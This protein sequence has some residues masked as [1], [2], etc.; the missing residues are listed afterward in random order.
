MNTSFKG[1]IHNIKPLISLLKAIQ[2]K[3]LASCSIFAEGLTFTV[4]ESRCVKAVAYVKKHLFTKYYKDP[5]TENFIF[6]IPLNT[7]IDCLGII[8]PFT[9]NRGNTD[10][11]CEMNY[12]GPGSRFRIAFENKEISQLLQFNLDT[13]QPDE[14]NTDLSITDEVG[15]TQKMII[16]SSWLKSALNDLDKSCQTISMTFSP[17]DPSFRITG[18]GADVICELTYPENS[19]PFVS[20]Q[21]NEEA[22]F[23]Y[24]YSHIMLCRRALDNSFEVS[25]EVASN[26]I[27]CMLFQMEG[28]DDIN[29]FVE[30]TFLTSVSF[31]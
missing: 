12:D 10:D 9:N 2:I 11:L 7:L 1:E 24:A 3:K 4:E 27:L 8:S 22:T 6:G 16:K 19:E 15:T 5:T 28:Q 13:V 20:F 29:N 25:L 30:Y 21:C 17:N 23:S 31:A 26:G 14:E 18:E